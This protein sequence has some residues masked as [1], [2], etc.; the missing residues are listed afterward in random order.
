MIITRTPFRI[1]FFGGISDYPQWYKKHG[2]KV[3]SVTI[4]KYCYISLR[5]LPPFF[6]YKSVI[7]Y[8]NREEVDSVFEIEHPSVKE[9][10]F[11]MNMHDGVEIMHT[12]DIPAKS[13]VGSSSAF[14]VGLLKSLNALQGKIVSKKTLAK[15]AIHIEQNMIKENVGSQDQ[16]ACSFGGLNKIEF[17]KEEEQ[18]FGVSPITISSHKLNF[19]Q[20]HLMLFYTGISRNASEIAKTQIDNL[21]KKSASIGALEDLVE[22]GVNVLNGRLDMINDFGKLL[23]EA[24]SIKR[25]LADCISTDDID[26]AYNDALRAGATGGKLLGAGGGGFLL[27]FV[28]PELQNKVKWSLKHLFEVSFKFDFVGSHIVHYSEQEIY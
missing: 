24:W 15:N 3:L 27:L 28:K 7:R 19:F 26:H 22:E 6:K 8:T 14:T 18:G 11:Y 4:N 2:G 9:C 12:S 10:L 23:H 1:S 21:D 17:F 20:S 16:V 13:G 5:R 25:G